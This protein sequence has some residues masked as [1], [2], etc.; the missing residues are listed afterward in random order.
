MYK[1]HGWPTS[2][3]DVALVRDGFERWNIFVSWNGATEV[4]EW[5]LQGSE[6]PNVNDEDWNDLASLERLAFET[7]FD[8]GGSYQRYMRVLGLDSSGRVLGVSEVLDITQ[9]DAGLPSF[10][11]LIHANIL[12]AWSLAPLRIQ[13]SETGW[14]NILIGLCGLTGLGV[15]FREALASWRSRRKPIRLGT[16][17]A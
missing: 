14:L 13:Q 8:L 11:I 12:Q 17:Q 10:S 4:T 6:N 9:E 16:G 2:D 15:G 3:P 5:I 7:R 1:W